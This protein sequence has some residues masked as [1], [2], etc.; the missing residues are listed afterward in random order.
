MARPPFRRRRRNTS[1]PRPGRRSG[2]QRGLR[3]LLI[4]AAVVSAYQLSTAGEVTWPG[5]LASRVGDYFS[6][7]AAGWQHGR[8]ALEKQGQRREGAPAPEADLRGRVVR[9]SDGDTISVLDG[10]GRQHKI[11]L[12]AIDTPELAQAH[13]KSA[14]EALSRRVYQKT[15]EVVVVD[16][17]DYQRKVGTVYRNGDNI[18]LDLVARGH[19]WWYEY[20][21][22]HEHPLKQAQQEARDQRLGLW[23]NRDPMPPWQWRRENRQR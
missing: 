17:D 4:L 1:N 7:E 13:G 11:R 18:N 14:R 8:E 5:A 9:V 22:P 6:R 2:W 19:A 12:Y 16:V 20:H 10:S 15:V 3:N 21:A 23:A